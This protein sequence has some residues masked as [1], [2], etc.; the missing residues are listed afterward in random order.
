[1]SDVTNFCTA[2][3]L[4]NNIESNTVGIKWLSGS[5]FEKFVI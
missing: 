1:V 2:I 4:I 5:C 3:K